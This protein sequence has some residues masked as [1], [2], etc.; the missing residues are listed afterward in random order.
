MQQMRRR[1]KNDEE[2]EEEAEQERSEDDQVL[3][4]QEDPAHRPNVSRSLTDSSRSSRKAAMYRREYQ[5]HRTQSISSDST[6]DEDNEQERPQRYRRKKKE[7]KP[8]S[9]EDW[10]QF[11]ADDK[12][13]HL[14]QRE[15]NQEE[16]EI[17]HLERSD[18]EKSTSSYHSSKHGDDVIQGAGD[19][20]VQQSN[21]MDHNHIRAGQGDVMTEDNVEEANSDATVVSVGSKK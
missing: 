20:M 8:E 15:D 12:E 5:R 16:R 21:H 4:S 19:V 17:E 6:G 2:A 10:V 13:R 18:G 11:E 14:V 9:D 3:L 7:K 1:M